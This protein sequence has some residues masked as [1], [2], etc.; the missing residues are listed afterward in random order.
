MASSRHSPLAVCLCTC[1][2]TG[3]PSF[4]TSLYSNT[5]NAFPGYSCLCAC[6]MSPV[7]L[8]K[9]TADT[10]GVFDHTG[11][12]M[13]RQAKRLHA[14][15]ELSCLTPHQSVPGERPPGWPGSLSPAAA[16]ASRPAHRRGR[17]GAHLPAG[18]LCQETLGLHAYRLFMQRSTHIVMVLANALAHRN[19]H[20]NPW[21]AAERCSCTH[22]S[23]F[24]SAG[25]LRPCW[26]R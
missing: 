25:L 7:H 21:H 16:P 12:G 26:S 9:L 3:Y 17:L 13:H 1:V 2:T 4:E 8:G 5:A 15:T 23:C 18:Q 24:T 22:A 10:L 20:T 19:S 11:R 6:V 14:I